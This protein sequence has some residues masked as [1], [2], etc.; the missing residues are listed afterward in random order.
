MSKSKFIRWA[1][2][3]SRND[4]FALEQFYKPKQK[5]FKKFKFDCNPSVGSSIDNAFTSYFWIHNEP[6]YLWPHDP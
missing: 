6:Y 2:A 1:I 5:Q 3:C 4:A